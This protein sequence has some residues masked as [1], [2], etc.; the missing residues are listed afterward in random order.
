[1][2]HVGDGEGE[3]HRLRLLL[4]YTVDGLHGAHTTHVANYVEEAPSIVQ[5]LARIHLLLTEDEA[6][7][8]HP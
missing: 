8:V 7:Q 3:D 2:D 1:M 5:G 4:Q 6:V